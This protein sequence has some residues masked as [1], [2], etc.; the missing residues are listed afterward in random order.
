MNAKILT[1]CFFLGFNFVFSQS[2][3]L[4]SIEPSKTTVEGVAYYQISKCQELAWFRDKVNSGFTEINAILTKN[5][6]C[7]TNSSLDTNYAASWEPIAYDSTKAYKGEFDGNGYTISNI[8]V[9]QSETKNGLYGLFGYVRGII[10]NLTTKSF[11]FDF[12]KDISK[13]N[14]FAGGI[15]AKSLPGARFENVNAYGFIRSNSV[16]MFDKPYIG[17]HLG[18]IVGVCRGTTLKNIAI[19][20]VF[21][22]LYSYSYYYPSMT[23]LFLDSSKIRTSRISRPGGYFFSRTDSSGSKIINSF[24]SSITSTQGINFDYSLI[25]EKYGKIYYENF[26]RQNQQ[27][28]SQIEVNNSLHKIGY[29]YTFGSYH[30]PKFIEGDS[31]AFVTLSE[32]D[33]LPIFVE[34]KSYLNDW[35]RKQPSSEGNKKW[36]YTN[37]KPIFSDDAEFDRKF[38]IDDG[39]Y[40]VSWYSKSKSA[41]TISSIQQLAGLSVISN[42]FHGFEADDFSGKTITLAAD[43]KKKDVQ[44]YMWWPIGENSNHPFAGTFLGNKKSIEGLNTDTLAY[45]SSLFGVLEGTVKSLSL[46]EIDFGGSWGAGVAIKNKGMIDSCIVNGTIKNR[47]GATGIALLNETQATIKNSSFDGT[48]EIHTPDTS[49]SWNYFVDTYNKTDLVVSGI[50]G[51]N[52]GLIENVS[53][54]GFV[55][56]NVSDAPPNDGKTAELKTYQGG[57]VAKNF[58]T[59]IVKKSVSKAVLNDLKRIA[60]KRY[61]YDTLFSGGICGYN[62]GTLHEVS[63]ESDSLL[64]LATYAGGI[65][66]YNSGNINRAYNNVGN[67]KTNSHYIGGIAGYADSTSVIKNSYNKGHI[68]KSIIGDINQTVLVNPIYG[69]IVAV[70]HSKSLIQ[71]S[72]N[73]DNFSVPVYKSKNDNYLEFVSCEKNA[74]MCDGYNVTYIKGIG[75][76]RIY[77]SFN[78]GVFA[79]NNDFS[80]LG[81]WSRQSYSR[82]GGTSV[83]N[84]YAVSLPEDSTV[85]KYNTDHYTDSYTFSKAAAKGSEEM[86][87]YDLEASDEASGT[88]LKALNSWVQYQNENFGSEFDSW[89]QGEEYPEFDIDLDLPAISSSS[90]TPSSSSAENGSSS[91]SKEPDAIWKTV[92]PSFHLAVEGMTVTLSNAQGGVVR[93]FDALGHLVA[94]K[95]LAGATTSITLQTPGNYIVRVNGT[96][97]MATLK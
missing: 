9:R 74:G 62:A 24:A 27:K 89:K 92:Q 16:D 14:F 17:D 58:K 47:I 35:V 90:S 8:C 2:T 53:A 51:K 94:S 97:R 43:L 21:M 78:L 41:F 85:G 19:D 80:A 49:L 91:S 79:D 36:N 52:Y 93:I 61:Y 3:Y 95:P 15:A 87:F 42:G 32:W 10:K 83:F 23:G 76:G 5:I 67:I 11:Y 54:N 73:I 66:G 46:T 70:G 26:W 88:L 63:A 48:V 69:G 37:N 33:S 71:N 20:S 68:K 22:E 29:G 45:F 39:N 40:D 6:N 4:T 50:V 55:F 82:I 1:T 86:A 31:L 96:S 18:I 65:T 7:Y 38:W 75:A 64:F 25:Y 28:T 34:A 13:D 81:D 12:S 84:S 57:I 30:P 72:F 44:L 59:G 56:T 77:N 60:I